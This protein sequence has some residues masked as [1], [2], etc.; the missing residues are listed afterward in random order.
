MKCK[1]KKIKELLPA[2]LEQGLDRA[3]AIRTEAHLK[4]CEDC[5]AE[6]V[7][8]RAMAAE[9]VPDP[10][11]AF[12]AEMPARIYREVQ[13]QKA[14]EQ[15]RRWPGLSRIME[16][17]KVPRLAWAATAL[18]VVAVTSWFIMHPAGRD[19][20]D[21]AGTLPPADKYAYEYAGTEGAIALSDLNK[22]ELDNV[23]TW[24][25][26]EMASLS[27]EIGNAALNGAEKYIIRPERDVL[28]EELSELNPRE[29]EQL[30]LMLEKWKPEV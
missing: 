14:P 16:R 1:D 5:R 20:T 27:N 25:N 26:S 28:Y 11:T 22:G 8:L 6:L 23:A 21:T 15:E 12:W 17:I 3:E 4:A 29:M 10:G 2:Y 24:A 18:V 13:K 19:V 30:S 9:P 7:L